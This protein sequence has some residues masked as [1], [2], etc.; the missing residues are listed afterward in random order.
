MFVGACDQYGLQVRPVAIT[1]VEAIAHHAR[2]LLMPVTRADAHFMKRARIAAN[3]CAQHGMLF[4][5]VMTTDAAPP[6]PPAEA[7][8]REYF[9]AYRVLEKEDDRLRGFGH[10]WP[11]AASELAYARVTPGQNIAL[12]ITGAGLEEKEVVVLLRRAFYDCRT[13]QLEPLESGKSGARTFRVTEESVPA[14]NRPMI[15]KLSTPDKI[16]QERS[17]YLLVKQKVPHRLYAALVDE[18]SL[19]GQ[20]FAI[21]V[22]CFLEHCDPLA[23]RPDAGPSCIDQLFEN[24]LGDLH[25]PSEIVAVALHDVFGE[26]GCKAIRWTDGLEEAALEARRRGAGVPST[27]ELRALIEELPR[28]EVRVGTVHGDLHL[29]NV[30]LPTGSNEAIII[31]YGNVRMGLPLVADP[32]CLEVS[33]TFMPSFLQKVPRRAVLSAYKEVVDA[34]RFPLAPTSAER[35]ED[36]VGKTSAAMVR[37]IREVSAGLDENPTSYSFAVAAY[38]LRFACYPDNGTLADRSVAYEIAALLLSDTAVE[39]HQRRARSIGQ[40]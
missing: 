31:D 19:R 20:R 38:L 33:L 21:A 39:I 30:F 18:K 3:Y 13:L 8:V 37:R 26:T 6:R 11:E 9:K 22:Y 25:K 17:G 2:A 1:E 34:Y 7:D 24:T 10:H 29:A 28:N 35:L 40:R 12:N 15:A 16:D 4:G 32:A 23:Q 5:L 27:T 14:A 36:L